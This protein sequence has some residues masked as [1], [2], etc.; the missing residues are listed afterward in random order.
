MADILYTNKSW[1][2]CFLVVTGLLAIV[3]FGLEFLNF[4]GFLVQ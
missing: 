1:F 4:D 3:L 2:A